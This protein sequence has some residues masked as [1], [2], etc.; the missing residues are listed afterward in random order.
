[1]PP[2]GPAR[3]SPPGEGCV[4]PAAVRGAPRPPRDAS[5][6]PPMTRAPPSSWTPVGGWPGSR[7]G[8][9]EDG[10]E[11]HRGA[12]DPGGDPADRQVP[13]QVGADG[14]EDDDEEDR[15][16]R[17]AVGR[18]G[19]PG[20][21]RDRG[22]H[23]R[24]QHHLDGGGGQH[25]QAEPA[26]D[27]RVGR[28]HRHRPEHDEVAGVEGQRQHPTQV[29]PGEHEEHADQPRPH[30]HPGAPPGRRLP[31]EH[32][33][34]DDRRRVERVD[35]RGVDR[36][37]PLEG[38]VEQQPVA[39]HPQHARQQQDAP[40]RHQPAPVRALDELGDDQQGHR[41]QRPPPPG[42]RQRVQRLDRPLGDEV[43]A[44]PEQRREDE[45]QGGGHAV[46][47]CRGAGPGAKVRG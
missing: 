31:Q 7:D 17:A 8:H 26:A 47:V 9:G 44:G 30:A 28:P 27:E 42:Q 40:P 24:R 22:Q 25:G 41:G 39:A 6:T 21:Q 5:R 15:A 37:R 35:D 32:G 14:G 13:A 12:R 16:P 20:E 29:P 18:H 19:Q 3:S 36:A 11:V 33:R 38:G 34:H 1:M 2:R 23:D 45:E 46:R 10:D 4:A 43:V